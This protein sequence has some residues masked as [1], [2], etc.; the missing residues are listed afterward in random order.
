VKLLIVAI[1][2]PCDNRNKKRPDASFKIRLPNI[3]NPRPLWLK[4][5][6]NGQPYPNLVIE[7]AVNNESPND[8]LADMQRYFRRQTSIRVWVGVEYWKRSRKFWVGWGE[9]RPGG[10]GGRLH[11]EFD[12]PP[13][14]HPI[15]LPTNIIYRIPMRTIFGPQIPIPANLPANLLIDTDEIRSTIISEVL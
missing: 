3:P 10:I 2:V 4:L 12:F 7:V 11:T 5:L 8:L 13:N 14:H 6:P 9:R 15:N 1:D